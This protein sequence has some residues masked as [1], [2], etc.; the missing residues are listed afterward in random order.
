MTYKI[1]F[2]GKED[3]IGSEKT[4]GQ[5]LRDKN[6]KPE[7][8][9]LEL[10]GSI[11][12][13]K[14]FESTGI[15]KNDNIEVIFFMGGGQYSSAVE[16]VLELIG[17]TPLVKL[18]R[19]TGGTGADIYAKL[20]F[21]NPGG[22]VKD[23]I[24]LAM[25]EDA[26]KQGLL[27]EGGTIIEPSSGNTGI[28]LALISALKGYTCIITM[29]EG[30]SLERIYILKS[31]G[32]EVKLSPANKGMAGAISMAEKL[33]Q[34][35]P[36]AYMPQQFKNAANPEY[37]YRITGPEIW[38]QM[39]GKID[40]F[41]AGIGTGGTVSGAGKYLKEQN[42]AI[43]IIGVEPEASPVLTEGRS[44]AHRIQGIGA[45]FVPE[46]LDRSV[47]DEII[48]VNDTESFRLSKELSTTEG[49]FVGV[50]SGAAFI[51]AKQA[52]QDLGK[53]R[54]GVVVFPD[55]GER[56]FSIEQHFRW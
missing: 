5:F 26:E 6:I 50:S 53:G 16:N 40:F 2:N 27:S 47:L 7:I 3:D 22:S 23:R 55:T 14:N 36:G 13:K 42:P 25:V 21:Y 43:K 32:A 38:S 18:G 37:H 10:N 29:P 41:V 56:Y 34:K 35:T 45:G 11:V 52:A 48:T 33:L 28:G 12:D 1:M 39:D 20:E 54:R 8:I 51:A 46:V 30:M 9:A 31:F 17:N 15:N 49:L 44:G 19:I 24:A 4:I